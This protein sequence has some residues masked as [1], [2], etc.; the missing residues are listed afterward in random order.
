M[1]FTARL[2]KCYGKYGCFSN[3]PPFNRMVL[4]PLSPSAISPKFDLYT[5][6][7]MKDPQTVNDH[8]L[9]MIQNSNFNGS[10]S[11]VF[12]VHGYTG[13]LLLYK[14]WG[15]PGGTSVGSQWY[16]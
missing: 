3:D 5:R 8:D 4:L 9:S 11:T 10:K 13:N 2:R 14:I 1:L 12:V 16:R 15:V 6:S 7:N